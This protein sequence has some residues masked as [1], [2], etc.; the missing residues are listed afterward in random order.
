MRKDFS[1]LLRLNWSLLLLLSFK[2]SAQILHLQGFCS[3]FV[4]V[5]SISSFFFVAIRTLEFSYSISV[6][7]TILVF[8]FSGFVVHIYW[9]FASVAIIFVRYC[10]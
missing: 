5:F 6:C 7:K 9:F 10:A 1:C 8:C 4:L 2:I 3:L